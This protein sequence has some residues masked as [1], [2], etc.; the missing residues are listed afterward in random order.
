[1]QVPHV[2]CRERGTTSRAL[3]GDS[4]Q[5]GGKGRLQASSILLGHLH[6]RAHR[7]NVGW[8]LLLPADAT[9]DAALHVPFL[10]ACDEQ[11]L[12]PE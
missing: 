3:M 10:P 1:M 5:P 11:G 9:M 4:G 7:G 2:L 12:K 8:G 6:N